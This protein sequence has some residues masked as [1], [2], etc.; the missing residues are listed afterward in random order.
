MPKLE[1]GTLAEPNPAQHTAKIR[2]HYI[3]GMNKN[4]APVLVCCYAQLEL[5]G[6]PLSRTWVQLS[7]ALRR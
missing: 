3:D 4:D 6:M 2:L 5:H 1:A 7:S